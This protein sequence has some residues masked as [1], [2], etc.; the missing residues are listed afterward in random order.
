MGK[1][2]FD[3]LSCERIEGSHP[4]GAVRKTEGQMKVLGPESI[5]V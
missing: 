4:L 5:G 1:P 2:T 3:P